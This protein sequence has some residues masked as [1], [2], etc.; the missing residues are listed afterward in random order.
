LV[1]QEDAAAAY[2]SLVDEQ[3]TS[4]GSGPDMYY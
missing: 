1:P 2:S 3:T 4:W